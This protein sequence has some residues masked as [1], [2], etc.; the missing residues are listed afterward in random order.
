MALANS[1]TKELSLA[2]MREVVLKVVDGKTRVKSPVSIRRVKS[3]AKFN[4]SEVPKSKPPKVLQAKPLRKIKATT[5]FKKELIKDIKAVVST[6][7]SGAKER[8]QAAAYQI[9]ILIFLILS[10][11]LLLVIW[12]SLL[13]ISPN[14]LTW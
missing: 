12:F 6:V 14:E 1:N 2:E 13:V 3:S 4:K 8:N 5:P 10:L 11:V 7:A 9:F